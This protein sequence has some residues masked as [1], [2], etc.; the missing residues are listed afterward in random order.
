MPP[1][2]PLNHYLVVP[3]TNKILEPRSY[4][5]IPCTDLSGIILAYFKHSVLF[6]VTVPAHLLHSVKSTAAGLNWTLTRTPVKNC[7]QTAKEH[8]QTVRENRMHGTNTHPQPTKC[9]L[10]TT[11]QTSH[12]TPVNTANDGPAARDT[13]RTTSFLT[14]TTL[15]YAIGAGIT[16]AAGTRLAL[17]LILVKGFIVYSFRLQGLGWVLHRYLSSL[18]PRTGN[19]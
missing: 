15:V 16:A 13:G 17:Q 14:A 4:S 11:G 5:I 8:T 19:G 10:S 9:S 12:D 7:E 3:E 1:T 2:V 6:K 18:P